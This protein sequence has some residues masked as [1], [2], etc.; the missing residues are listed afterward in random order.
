MTFCWSQLQSGEN[1]LGKVAYLFITNDFLVNRASDLLNAVQCSSPATSAETCS[2][3]VA[4]YLRSQAHFIAL[5]AT[6]LKL[7]S[8]S[9]Y[10]RWQTPTE[11]VEF[12]KLENVVPLN[13][14]RLPRTSDF[15][16]TSYFRKRFQVH[17]RRWGESLLQFLDYETWRRV[18][19][20]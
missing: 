15:N 8:D 20:C 7:L 16:C 5:C 19:F 9:L 1:D 2:N 3:S 13:N 18:S 17:F 14:N 6:G 11:F 4:H 12:I 10:S